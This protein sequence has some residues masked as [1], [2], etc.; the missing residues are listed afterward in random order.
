MTTVAVVTGAAGLIG[1]H[2]VRHLVDHGSHVIALDE[3]DASGVDLFGASRQSRL[4]FVRADTTNLADMTSIGRDVARLYG[5]VDHFIHA[6]A[7]TALSDSVSPFGDVVGVD[8]DVWRRI[9]DINLTGALISLR[10]LIELLRAADRAKVLFLGSI[11]GS[12]PTLETGSYAVS[13]AALVALARQ[14]AAELAPLRITVNVLSLGP[15][16][17][18]NQTV[19]DIGEGPTPMRRFGRLDEVA[20]ATASLLGGCFDYM[21]GAVIPL[22]GG[23]HLRPRGNP[24]RYQVAST[25]I[26]DESVEVL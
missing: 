3:R 16:Q 17:T 22:D 15:I 12:V 5:H 8:P 2:L 14:L 19:P 24:P 20:E 9:I 23:E 11:Q 13:K 1:G 6:A 21:T 25:A 10:S 7:V 18:T 26:R 4:T